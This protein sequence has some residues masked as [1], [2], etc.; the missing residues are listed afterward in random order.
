MTD[1]DRLASSL[2][3]LHVGGSHYSLPAAEAA[4]SSAAQRNLL[5][6]EDIVEGML[7]TVSGRMPRARVLEA[8]QVNDRIIATL[9]A[10]RCVCRVWHA[11]GAKPLLAAEL[12]KRLVRFKLAMDFF[13]KQRAENTLSVKPS[14]AMLR[15]ADADRVV[16]N[17]LVAG[18]EAGF[19]S[20]LADDPGLNS[21]EPCAATIKHLHEEGIR[22]PF[23]IIAP[24]TTWPAW[25]EAL[26]MP[27]LPVAEVRTGEE[28]DDHMEEWWSIHPAGGLLFIPIDASPLILP[29][30]ARAI[31]SPGRLDSLREAVQRHARLL[32]YIVLDQRQY[33]ERGSLRHLDVK[34]IVPRNVVFPGGNYVRLTHEPLPG[35]VPALLRVLAGAYEHLLA[36]SVDLE[37]IEHV[38]QEHSRSEGQRHLS[39][40]ATDAF[41]VPTLQHCL[42]RV[43]YRRR[44]KR[45][46]QPH[47][48]ETEA[49]KIVVVD[50][51]DDEHE[52]DLHPLVGCVV[53][54]RSSDS[55]VA[56]WQVGSIG[57]AHMFDE[58]VDRMMV[59]LPN[60]SSGVH[61]P[62]TPLP[63][64]WISA[65]E[66]NLEAW[67][68]HDAA[69]AAAVDTYVAYRNGNL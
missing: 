42:S 62:A 43:L 22:G 63:F 53:R 26:N 14:R 44:L 1:A 59:L 68:E 16:C 25:T 10:A 46:G 5:S 24:E 55:S 56:S 31:A 52:T 34:D 13:A 48:V 28:L 58:R 45:G 12:D 60:D 32:K 69:W 3:G 29:G 30:G 35:A 6:D 50:L 20:V 61:D 38:L 2:A 9:R 41:L 65:K 23:W 51:P 67:A 66:E 40:W 49:P 47:T 4:P 19:N 37:D 39:R 7:F 8:Q 15:L 54:V 21:V 17:W 33:S 27:D 36:Q 18:W 57:F 11:A 64:Q